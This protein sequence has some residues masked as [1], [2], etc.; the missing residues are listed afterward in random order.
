MKHSLD[1]A[2]GCARLRRVALHVQGCYWRGRSDA[3]LA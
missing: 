3:N 1:H 2:A